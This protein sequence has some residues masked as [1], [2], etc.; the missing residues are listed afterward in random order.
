MRAGAPAPT[1]TRPLLFIMGGLPEL[2]AVGA[3]PSSVSPAPVPEITFIQ[4]VG[5][6]HAPEVSCAV[7]ATTPELF[8][9]GREKLN[10]VA[11]GRAISIMPVSS[12][13]TIAV[14]LS[15]FVTPIAT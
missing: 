1:K 8:T 15:L 4:D 6:E 11:V 14:V 3:M 10:K 9:D 2:A 12:I 7:N 13:R 5:P